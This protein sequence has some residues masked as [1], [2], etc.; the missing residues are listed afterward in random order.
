MGC[1]TFGTGSIGSAS[2]G[3]LIKDFRAMLSDKKNQD[4]DFTFDVQK[5]TMESVAQLLAKFLGKECAKLK[6]PELQSINIGFLIGG[7][8]TGE[9]L[10]ESWAVEIRQGVPGAP[11]KLREKD[12]PGINWGGEAEVLQRIV[13]G[14]SPRIF[15]VLAQVGQ[16]PQSPQQIADKLMP[17]LVARAQAPMVFAPMPIQ[18]ATDLARFLVHSAEMFSRFIPGPQIVGGPIE[19]AAITKH[20]GFKW[21]SRKHYY[22]QSL[23]REPIDVRVIND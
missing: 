6:P 19:I 17:L 10:G 2:I 7:Y 16:P 13:L 23:N 11:S 5:Y 18:D 1:V 4:K 8:S 3:T 9:S 12:Q 21:I 22:D 14:F 20:E 15:E